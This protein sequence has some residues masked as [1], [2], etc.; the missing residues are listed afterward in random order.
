MDRNR[1]EPYLA[2]DY[3]SRA[4]ASSK[5]SAEAGFFIMSSWLPN[6]WDFAAP[7]SPIRHDCLRR[8]VCIRMCTYCLKA[9]HWP[10]P[11]CYTMVTLGCRYYSVVGRKGVLELRRTN[12]AGEEF[13]QR[14]NYVS[15][16][17][18]HTTLTTTSRYLNIHRRQ[19]QLAMQRLKQHQAE[20]KLLHRRCTTPT[21]L[22]Q[23]L[24][25]TPTTIPPVSR[26][27]LSR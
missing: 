20:H 17:L 27:L 18:G 19:R 12:A 11:K 13:G 6:Q 9:R 15:K 3:L 26:F 21:N 4:A 25:R 5:C 24:C 7:L 1:D 2:G 22:H 16:I 23:P 8:H 10:H 14:A